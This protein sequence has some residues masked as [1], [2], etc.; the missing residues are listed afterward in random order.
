MRILLLPFLFLAMTAMTFKGDKPKITKDD[1][2]I[3][4]DG[5]AYFKY[6]WNMKYNYGMSI[7]KVNGEKLFFL[8]RE[9]YVDPATMSKSNPDGK[10]H[11]YSLIREGESEVSCEIKSFTAKSLARMLLD[12]GVLDEN[13]DI[14]EESFHRMCAQ[15]G[16]IYSQNKP[17]NIRVR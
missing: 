2:T 1:N 4:V 13:G 10:V 17:V 9:E 15:A 5:A 8:R 16:K 11:Y 6:K 12:Y 3:F 7:D 14:R